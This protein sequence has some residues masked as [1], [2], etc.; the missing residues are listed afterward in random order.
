MK[1][2][3]LPNSAGPTITVAIQPTALAGAGTT[4]AGA[5][6]DARP[7][8]GW[9]RRWLGAGPGR[10]NTAVGW[11][12][13]VGEVAVVAAAGAVVVDGGRSRGRGW[14]RG[15]IRAGARARQAAL[16][17]EGARADPRG[18]VRRAAASGPVRRPWPRLP[19]AKRTHDA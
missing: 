2:L 16:Q 8:R 11:D 9:A 13:A 4:V 15:P 6:H 18:L 14:A 7:G 17:L 19:L 1:G 10:A 12:G 3:Y 5:G